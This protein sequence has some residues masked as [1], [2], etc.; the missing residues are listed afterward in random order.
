[1]LASGEPYQL[2]VSAV[3]FDAASNAYKVVWSQ[4][5][6]EGAPMSDARLAQ[7]RDRLIPIMS[8]QEV[9]ILVETSA[10]YRPAFQVGLS[11]KKFRNFIAMRPRF[12]ST[13]CWSAS[14]DPPWIGT[15]QVC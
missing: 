14:N 12:V 3:R 13:L 5:R 8:D 1:M 15:D 10:D 11:D 2:R 6:G 9:Q 7:L 4:V